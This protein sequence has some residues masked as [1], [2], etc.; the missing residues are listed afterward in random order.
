MKSYISDTY[1]AW[2]A[3]RGGPGCYKTTKA[4]EK[5]RTNGAMHCV[6]WDDGHKL[7]EV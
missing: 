2:L 7:I 6:G 5:K 1:L 4:C 3:C